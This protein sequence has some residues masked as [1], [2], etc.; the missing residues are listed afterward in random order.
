MRVFFSG[1][2]EFLCRCYGLSG[3]SG[4]PVFFFRKQKLVH[5]RDLMVGR[6][7]C[8]WCDIR[9]DQLKIPRADRQRLKKRTLE[10]LKSDHDDF[11]KAGG[12]LKKAKLYNNA[13][14]QHFFDIPLTQVHVQA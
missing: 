3:A 6:H 1:D 7:C 11:L 10:S 13:I 4:E 14:S 12:D 2:Y 5:L 8:L 9:S